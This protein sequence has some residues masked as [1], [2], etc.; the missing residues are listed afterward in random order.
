M[1]E[2]LKSI[3]LIN[4]NCKLTEELATLNDC[5]ATMADSNQLLV[6]SLHQFEL[7]NGLSSAMVVK[8]SGRAGEGSLPNDDTI[9]VPPGRLTSPAD[10]RDEEMVVKLR[11]GAGDGALLD[12]TTSVALSNIDGFSQGLSFSPQQF[13]QVLD[14]LLGLNS[15]ASMVHPHDKYFLLS[16]FNPTILY[17]TRWTSRY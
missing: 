5:L 4:K 16:L 3:L 2:A 11:G 7:G 8:S 6:D 15:P 9:S 14:I 10:A 12:C 1:E 17:R 13:I